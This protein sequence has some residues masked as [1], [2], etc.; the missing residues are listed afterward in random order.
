K[1]IHSKI[2]SRKCQ[3]HR[4]GI[5]QHNAV[6]PTIDTCKQCSLTYISTYIEN[7]VSISHKVCIPCTIIVHA[8]KCPFI[9]PKLRT[10]NRDPV[11]L[12]QGIKPTID[13]VRK[14]V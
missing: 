9:Y 4:V 13:S 10:P 7:Y 5:H 12:V 2:S 1:V 11:C 8:P 14:K 3:R 6:W